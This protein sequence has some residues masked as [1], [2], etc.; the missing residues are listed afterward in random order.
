MFL[1][2]VGDGFK[3]IAGIDGPDEAVGAFNG[4]AIAAAAKFVKNNRRLV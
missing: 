4:L 1:L 2:R 3:R